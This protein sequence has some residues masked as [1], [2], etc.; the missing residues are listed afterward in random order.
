VLPVLFCLLCLAL[1]PSHAGAEEIGGDPGPPSTDPL[2]LPTLSAGLSLTAGYR[3]FDD[4]D[5]DATYGGLATFGLEGTLSVGERAWF[6]AGVGYGRRSGDPYHDRPDFT[7]GA[8]DL[9][10]VPVCIGLRGDFAN[11]PRIG[12]IGT[13]GLEA[14]WVEE[15]LPS[16]DPFF[17]GETDVTDGWIRGL[18]FAIGPEWRST[19]GR[20]AMGLQF[21]IGGAEGD[22]GGG[23]SG[24]GV[25]LGG[26]GVRFHL[27]HDFGRGGAS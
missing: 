7:G 24:H 25:N 8:A 12:L 23:Y 16:G 18:V 14:A 5:M 9:R 19:D 13:V 3:L 22:I 2:R 10:A 1:T 21:S 15:S 17:S 27:T 11:H 6:F 20:L 26:M 4:A